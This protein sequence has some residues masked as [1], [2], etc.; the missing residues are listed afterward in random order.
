L[1]VNVGV[2]QFSPPQENRRV[3]IGDF[4]PDRGT[5][6]ALKFRAP[7]LLKRPVRELAVPH[8]QKIS[9]DSRLGVF[10]SL[11]ANERDPCRRTGPFALAA[12]LVTQLL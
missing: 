10:A 4:T 11:P 12:D 7:W 5:A 2:T 6:C 8:V 1:L 9:S 3:D